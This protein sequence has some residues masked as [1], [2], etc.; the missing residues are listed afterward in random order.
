[1][2]RQNMIDI[3]FWFLASPLRNKI[4]DIISIL[5]PLPYHDTDTD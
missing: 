4:V 5:P 1:M 3:M 2:N